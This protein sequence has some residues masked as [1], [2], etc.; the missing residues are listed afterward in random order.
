MSFEQP[1][2]L[3]EGLEDRPVPR[4]QGTG[5]GPDQDV[6]GQDPYDRL[7]SRVPELRVGRQ[8]EILFDP[9]VGV[10][11]APPEIQEEARRLGSVARRRSTQLLSDHERLVMVA[12]Q[13]LQGSRSLHRLRLALGTQ[14]SETASQ[15]R[16]VSRS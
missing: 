7:V 10:P 14:V 4:L 9:E 3:V 2:E 13:R 1:A 11:V 8:E 16:F 12:R 6:V 15:A 5:P